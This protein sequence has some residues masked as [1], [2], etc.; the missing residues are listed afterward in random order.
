[1]QNQEQYCAA[2]N[3]Q[4][5]RGEHH[6]R[7]TEVPE[8]GINEDKYEKQGCGDGPIEGLQSVLEFF[9]CPAIF[10]RVAGG[11]RDVLGNECLSIGDDAPHRSA[12][13]VCFYGNVP[14]GVHASDFRQTLPD[15]DRRQFAKGDLLT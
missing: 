6:D 9:Y 13:D 10:D 12:L 8:A 11:N 15:L 1:M 5:N 4:R 7:I 14:L 2:N 3:R